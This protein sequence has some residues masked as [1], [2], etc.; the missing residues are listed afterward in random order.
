MT[1][2]SVD[3]V[4]LP[5]PNDY[6]GPGTYEVQL[7]VTD[8]AGDENSLLRTLTVPSVD[9]SFTLQQVNID[10]A[11]SPL[12]S[13]TRPDMSADGRYVAFLSF[14]DAA[15]LEPDTGPGPRLYV[16][17][18]ETGA[19]TRMPR[20]ETLA[21]VWIS[22]RMAISGD[23][24]RVAFAA[25][26]Q[27]Y[28]WDRN[29]GS[30]ELLTASV[31]AGEPSN[32]TQLPSFAIDHTGDRA[33]IFSNATDLTEEGDSG[34]FLLDRNADGPSSIGP[35]L[36]ATERTI[37]LSADGQ[38]ALL[39]GRPG[40][41]LGDSELPFSL[42]YI[43]IDL[44]T[45]ER[46]WISRAEDG[47]E[48]NGSSLILGRFARGGRDVLFTTD[49][50]NLGPNSNANASQVYRWSHESGGLTQLTEEDGAFCDPNDPLQIL[51]IGA[52]QGMLSAAGDVFAWQADVFAEV[53][54]EVSATAPEV[55][56]RALDDGSTARLS[57]AIFN[58]GGAA[59]LNI[60]DPRISADGRTISFLLGFDRI[61][62][63]HRIDDE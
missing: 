32:A 31:D 36:P 26:N 13:S 3:V 34:Y 56:V 20:P 59:D 15:G 30:V 6:P 48:P 40:Q 41:L 27:V 18:L 38:L 50:T 47:S 2:G 17:D 37:D 4:L 58:A 35:G 7:T 5:S 23:G 44:E 8:A 60:R 21:D 62:H 54:G 12:P 39:A 24:Q 14:A 11:D 57:P 29:A 63:A 43:V 9:A 46:T 16:R 28:L 22:N 19:L 53:C 61:F 45:D 52:R 10:S 33:L 51:R 49:A 1:I 55:L 25:A 42:Q